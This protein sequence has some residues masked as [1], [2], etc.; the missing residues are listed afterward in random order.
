LPTAQNLAKLT[1]HIPAGFRQVRL[2]AAV[3]PILQLL[4]PPPGVVHNQEPRTIC[5]ASP[6][7]APCQP[8]TSPFG[9]AP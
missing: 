1:V 8:V 9:V 3:W 6:A 2:T 7:G 5:L 4:Q